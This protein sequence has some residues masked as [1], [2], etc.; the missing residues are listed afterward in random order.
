MRTALLALLLLQ[1]STTYDFEKDAA[2][3][4][5][6][7]FTTA[8]TG[9]G[10]PAIWT[11]REEAGAPSGKQ[12]LAQTSAEETDGRFPLCLSDRFSAKDG[13]VSVKFKPVSGK[14]DQAGGVVFRYKDKDN[15]YIARANALEDN[16]RLYKV[17]GG[18]RRQFA[19]ANAKVAAGQWHSLKL[20]VKGKHFKVAFDDKPLFEA[21]DDTFKDA[22]KA[23]LWTKA[24][25]VTLFDDLVLENAD[26][27]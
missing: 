10:G 26:L 3:K 4:T 1:T 22:G 13:S 16:V 15:Y 19:N 11:V 14:I 8:L 18:N 12:V 6:D 21:D 23:G 25:S 7:G 9:A 24:D 27:K 5:P 20:E 2:G 17:V